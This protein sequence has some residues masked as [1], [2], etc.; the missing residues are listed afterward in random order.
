MKAARGRTVIVHAD[1]GATQIPG[2]IQCVRTQG[3]TLD[4]QPEL[5]PPIVDVAYISPPYRL[6]ADGS[7]RDPMWFDGEAKYVSGLALFE[8]IQEGR[9]WGSAFA[10][11]PP[12]D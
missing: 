1:L 6:R 2:V 5:G 4:P 3:D 11:V 12:R 10:Y 9:A 8:T 7:G